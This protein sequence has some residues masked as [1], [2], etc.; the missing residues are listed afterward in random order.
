MS[1]ISSILKRNLDNERTQQLYLLILTLFIAGLLVSRAA[2]SIATISFTVL[3]ILE[4]LK[5]DR[6]EWPR[7]QKYFYLL[8]LILFA[9]GALS[10]FYSENKQSWLNYMRVWLPMVS[11][12]FSFFM[13]PALSARRFFALLSIYVF[14]VT[15]GVLWS[16]GQFLADPQTIIDSYQHAKVLPTP[17]GGDHVRFALCVVLAASI[18]VVLAMVTHG[19]F[20]FFRGEK[21]LWIILSIFLFLYLHILA[22]KSGLL[23]GW[24][25]YGWLAVFFFIRKNFKIAFLLTAILFITPILSYFFIPTFQEKLGYI[26]YEFEEHEKTGRVEYLSDVNRLVSYSLAWSSIQEHPVLGVGLGDINEE[27]QSKYKEYYPEVVSGSVLLPHNQ[28]LCNGLAVGFPGMIILTM[29]YLFPLTV[30]SYRLSYMGITLSI[31]GLIVLMVEP[32]LMTQYSLTTY[33]FLQLLFF[34]NYTSRTNKDTKVL[35]ACEKFS[36]S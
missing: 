14:I 32:A 15:L 35:F 28:W 19:K 10:F 20:M 29:L 9:M 5:G 25:S 1:S 31:V 8:Y 6:N 4:Y 2:L 23:A 21:S 12:P 27:I 34:S 33:M 13:I 30:R 11:L 24:M 17:L 36:L 3:A 16:L 22:V 7:S 26:Q 18:S